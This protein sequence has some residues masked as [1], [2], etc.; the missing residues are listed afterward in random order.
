M[1]KFLAVYLACEIDVLPV[2]FKLLQ[3]RAMYAGAGFVH[4]YVN[5]S[6]ANT[7]LDLLEYFNSSRTNDLHGK[8]SSFPIW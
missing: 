4:T 6:G 5:K 8:L 2:F 7:M 1:F 3:V